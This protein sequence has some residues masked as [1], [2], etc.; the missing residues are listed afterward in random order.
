MLRLSIGL[1][2]A[3][4]F[5]LLASAASAQTKCV[6][7]YV[8]AKGDCVSEQAAAAARRQAVIF[9]EPKISETAYPVLPSSDGAY[10]YPNQLINIPGAG[11]TPIGKL[12]PS[13]G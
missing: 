1:P 5:V 12:A 4:A 13:G 8:S 9:S 3:A 2:A 11:V 7:G 6:A 10:R